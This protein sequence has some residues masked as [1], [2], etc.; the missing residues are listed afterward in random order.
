MKRQLILTASL[1]TLTTTISIAQNQPSIV[2][3]FNKLIQE[4]TNYQTYKVVKKD[5]LELLQR[6]VSDSLDSFKNEIQTNNAEI[7]KQKASVDSLSQELQQVQDELNIALQR[8]NNLEVLGVSTNKTTYQTLV[9]TIIAVL[10]SSLVVLFFRFKKS[11]IDT[12]EAIKKL[13]ETE[14]ELEDLR[15]LSLER[16]QKIRRQLQDEINKNKVE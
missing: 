2:E 1:L 14:N 4:S 6:N 3:Q 13:H 9:W 12:K 11:H 8:E 15:R 10:L 7:L 16:E 5:N